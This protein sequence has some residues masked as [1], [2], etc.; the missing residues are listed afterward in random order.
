MGVAEAGGA[1]G[2]GGVGDEDGGVAGR[3]GDRGVGVGGDVE[4]Q[5]D[6]ENE[7]DGRD[8]HE[9][10]RGNKQ[11]KCGERPGE[12]VAAKEAEHGDTGDEEN[13]GAG[14]LG[15]PDAIAGEGEGDATFRR[16]DWGGD[17]GG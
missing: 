4:T 7:Q 6:G 5:G 3:T 9:V 12:G 15:T 2:A 17:G 11:E 10:E 1:V 14:G 16:G 13:G 8:D